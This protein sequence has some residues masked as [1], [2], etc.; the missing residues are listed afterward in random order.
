MFFIREQFSISRP[1]RSSGT[2]KRQ[3]NMFKLWRYLSYRD[4]HNGESTVMRMNQN[5]IYT[6]STLES[7]VFKTGFMVT[8]AFISMW[9]TNTATTA[10]M[11]PIMEA[12]LKQLD[13][14]F[15][16]DENP[17]DKDEKEQLEADA[18]ASNGDVTQKLIPNDATKPP[19]KCTNTTNLSFFNR[20]Q[21]VFNA[22]L[23]QSSF[24][25][26]F[27]LI[28]WFRPMK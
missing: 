6:V 20:V 16:K 23:T 28:T 4:S 22:K 25:H 5:N 19:H 17:Q 13:K 10:M 11:T 7:L 12:V 24:F 1:E 27:A 26:F 18:V 3:E 2:L 9:I 14:K 21:R 15:Q 8:T